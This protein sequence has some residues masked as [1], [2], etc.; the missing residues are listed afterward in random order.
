MSE[1][2]QIRQTSYRTWEVEGEND[3]YVVS[4]D[5]R[6]RWRCTC[7]GFVTHLKPCKHIGLVLANMGRG[8]EDE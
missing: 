6:G 2:E 7:P 1:V 5:A 4:I 8:E 3:T